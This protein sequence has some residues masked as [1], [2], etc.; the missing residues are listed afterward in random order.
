MGT[1][2]CILL[3]TFMRGSGRGKCRYKRNRNTFT[4]ESLYYE[5]ISE[6]RKTTGIFAKEVVS[7]INLSCKLSCTPCTPCTPYYVIPFYIHVYSLLSSI[8][9]S[10]HHNSGPT[11]C[12][13]NSFE[14]KRAMVHSML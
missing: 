4:L 7:A 8:N 9:I 6:K 2:W 11:T 13:Y 10:R 3:R 1:V 12:G 5:D 14:R